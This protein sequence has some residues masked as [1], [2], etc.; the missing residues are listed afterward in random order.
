MKTRKNLFFTFMIFFLLGTTLNAQDE[1]KTSGPYV[2]VDL[3]YGFGAGV[4]SNV[5]STSLEALGAEVTHAGAPNETRT[6]IYGSN[7][8]GFNATATIGHKLNQFF[9]FELGFNYLL[10]AR[11]TTA[12]FSTDTGV[13]DMSET[14]TKQFRIKPSLLFEAGD[15]D[16]VPYSRVG[17]VIP[18][19]GASYGERE[20]NTPA[21]LS[22][23]VPTL[24]PDAVS[25]KAESKSKGQFG[26]G[27]EGAVGAKYALSDNMAI[28]AELFYTSL[29]VKRKTYEITK[30]VLINSDGSEADVI[31]LLAA[32]GAVQ[33]V[34]YKDEI[35][36]AELEA[37]ISE[38]GME[39]GTEA[40]P[41][42]ALREDAL[43]NALGINVGFTFQF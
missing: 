11:Q 43:F 31:P 25:F 35:N 2:R 26:L 1:A 29:R 41:A 10:G 20:L 18:V 19:A 3:G 7:G 27:F 42:W 9:G 33:F 37:Y 28:S 4:D 22:P 8:K 5:G 15:K 21:A 30:A 39:Y 14:Y 16:F 13:S 36:D 23:L 32:G 38:A 17:L 24:Y 34:E 40:K 12:D 6:N